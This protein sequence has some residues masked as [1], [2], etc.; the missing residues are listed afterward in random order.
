M[1]TGWSMAGALLDY[2]ELSDLL[3]ERHRIIAS[4]W[5]AAEMSSLAGR[6]L[7][8]AVEILDKV[9]CKPAAI[10]ADLATGR[11]ASGYLYSAAELIGRAAD[12]LSDGAGLVRENERRWRIFHAAVQELAED[13]SR[14]S[15]D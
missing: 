11:A 1:S 8:R 9:D 2:P 4:D 13:K 15:T 6:L 5:Q 3:G 14:S 7:V 12:L 10:R